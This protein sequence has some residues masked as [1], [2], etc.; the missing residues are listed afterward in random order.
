MSKT[1]DALA[2][3]LATMPADDPMAIRLR[4]TLANER[5]ISDMKPGDVGYM[6]VTHNGASRVEIVKVRKPTK[7]ERNEM[8]IIG[9]MVA[10]IIDYNGRPS[11][12]S[13]MLSVEA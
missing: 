9:G 4:K 5:C 1:N 3:L 12:M 6:S 8:T 10:D 13:G 11:V 7:A 2:A